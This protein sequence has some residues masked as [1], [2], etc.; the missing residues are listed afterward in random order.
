MAVPDER[1][2][3]TI[4]IIAFMHFKVSASSSR[5]VS[6]SRTHGRPDSYMPCPAQLVWPKELWKKLDM[7]S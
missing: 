2:E 1:T 3:S 5:G 6:V 4:A 7:E